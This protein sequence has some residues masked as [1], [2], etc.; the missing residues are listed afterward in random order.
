MCKYKY[1]ELVEIL[2]LMPLK[3]KTCTILNGRILTA[4][5]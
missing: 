2:F 1:Y 3:N 4:N 5:E